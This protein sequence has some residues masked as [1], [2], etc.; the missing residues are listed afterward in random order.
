MLS[1]HNKCFSETTDIVLVL[2]GLNWNDLIAVI[3]AMMDSEGLF[4]TWECSEKSN[5]IAESCAVHVCKAKHSLATAGKSSTMP[6]I[7]WV[8]TQ[9]SVLWKEVYEWHD[10]N[11]KNAPVAAKMTFQAAPDCN[12]MP[13]M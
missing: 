4:V 5:Q 2:Y 3:K 7:M 9:L 1:A 11:K 8:Y 12:K 6:C 13:S 10:P